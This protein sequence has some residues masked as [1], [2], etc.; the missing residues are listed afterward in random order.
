[1]LRA[2]ALAILVAAASPCVAEI[3]DG[4]IVAQQQQNAPQSTPK[5]DC[6]KK[7]EGIS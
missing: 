7:Q 3:N 2:L 1:M 4:T 5:R 6:E